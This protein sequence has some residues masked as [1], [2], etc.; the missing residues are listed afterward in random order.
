MKYFI[1]IVSLK[2]F[3]SFRFE[4]FP[5]YSFCSLFQLRHLLIMWILNGCQF[6]FKL[7]STNSNNN[8]RQSVTFTLILGIHAFDDYKLINR[9]NAII[10]CL[11]YTM[12]WILMMF[13][14]LVHTV[15]VHTV[16]ICMYL[17]SEWW[18]SKGVFFGSCHLLLFT[19]F[20]V[21]CTHYSDPA[22]DRVS[23]K[24]DATK[25]NIVVKFM[26]SYI[27]DSIETQKRTHTYAQSP[28]VE[29]TQCRRV[30][31]NEKKGLQFMQK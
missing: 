8:N 14:T 24:E 20:Y 9:R 23:E 16:W 6:S 30:E 2:L 21:C 13:K 1:S 27:S 25:N 15:C 5:F 29:K 7:K 10:R 17:S 31:R 22:L 28:R 12:W 11:N 18:P 19:E 3:S 26:G 4:C